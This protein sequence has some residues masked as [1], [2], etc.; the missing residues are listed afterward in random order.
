MQIGSADVLGLLEVGYHEVAGIGTTDPTFICAAADADSVVE[1]TTQL[2]SRLDELHH[3]FGAARRHRPGRAAAA[4]AMSHARRI[5]R[6]AVVTALSGAGTVCRHARVR[7]PVQPADDLPALVIEDVG[8]RSATAT[9]P[10]CRPV[11]ALGTQVDIERRYASPSSPRSSRRP[12]LPGR[13]MTCAP[14][15][16][17]RS[18]PPSTRTTSRA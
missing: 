13:A 15:S 9:S 5:I 18:T 2:T 14:K 8:P 4:G 12:S 16:R 1:G 17:P 10:R 7:P 3:P 6:E 11:N